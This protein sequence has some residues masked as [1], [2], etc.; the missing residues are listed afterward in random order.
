MKKLSRKQHEL[1]VEALRRYTAFNKGKSL[2]EAWTGLGYATDYMPVLKN[3]LMR[4]ASNAYPRALSWWKLT[5]KGAEI[6]KAW[7]DDGYNFK[8]I[9]K[10]DLPPF[11][12][13][14]NTESN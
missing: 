2:T 3:G 7:I 5:D 9:D 4:R 11:E 6:V 1:L 10:G 8:T 12:I 13:K 14:K